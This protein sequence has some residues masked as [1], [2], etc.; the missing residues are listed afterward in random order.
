MRPGGPLGGAGEVKAAAGGRG[1]KKAHIFDAH[2]VAFGAFS[3]PLTNAK[4]GALLGPTRFRR[5][6]KMEQFRTKSTQSM[7]KL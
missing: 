6:A 5:G 3:V 1:T 7:K 4:M 2:R